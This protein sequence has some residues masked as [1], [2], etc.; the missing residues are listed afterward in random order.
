MINLSKTLKGVAVTVPLMFVVGAILS[1]FPDQ[2][3]AKQL[4]VDAICTSFA[5]AG[6]LFAFAIVMVKDIF[7][8]HTS[9]S[10][11][12]GKFLGLIFAMFTMAWFFPFELLGITAIIALLIGTFI[13]YS[14]RNFVVLPISA[15]IMSFVYVMGRGKTE[16]DINVMPPENSGFMVLVKGFATL[17]GDLFGSFTGTFQAVGQ[18]YHQLATEASFQ[19]PVAASNQFV[20]AQQAEWVFPIAVAIGIVVALIYRKRWNEV[21]RAISY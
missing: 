9:F 14:K 19:V 4:T 10:G 20:G 1:T 8:E 21:K 18:F 12:E 3:L 16:L 5:V 17:L 15:W 2:Q 6:P 7:D 11:V 13:M